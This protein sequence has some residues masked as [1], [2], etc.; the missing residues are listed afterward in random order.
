[1]IVPSDSHL[2]TMHTR[3]RHH[4]DVPA[5]YNNK[6]GMLQCV[7]PPGDADTTV[8]FE[9]LHGGVSDARNW[10]FLFFCL[11]YFVLCSLLVQR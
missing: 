8:R 4:G 11:R 10:L 3:N 2:S 5:A 7:A 9:V 1:M 6:T